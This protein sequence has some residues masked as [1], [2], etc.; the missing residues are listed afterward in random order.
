MDASVPARWVEIIAADG[1]SLTAHRAEPQGPCRGAVVVV[2]EIFGVNEHIRAVAERFAQDGWLALAPQLFD[3]IEPG[4]E[5]GYDAEGV[6]RGQALAWDRL[7]RETAL[8]DLAAV[9]TAAASEIGSRARVGMVGF[10]FGGMLTAAAATRL[11]ECLGA[12]VAYYPSLAAQLLGDDPL[13]LPLAVHLGDTDQ[14]VTLA[15]GEVLEA[16]WPQATFWHYP[17]GHGFN[18]DLR[19]GYDADAAALAWSRTLEFLD[20]NLAGDA[21]GAEGA[22]DS[23]LA[24]PPR[25]LPN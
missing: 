6:K 16:R 14:R 3:R 17:A 4:V 12:A 10:C 11:P 7:D 13:L 2:Q 8:G 25:D 9:A 23:P 19:P 18:C 21:P 24:A 20:H 1:F 22:A 5:L 15:D